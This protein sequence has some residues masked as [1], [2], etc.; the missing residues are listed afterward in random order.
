MEPSV[1]THGPLEKL[2]EYLRI[3][4]YAF[5]S[6]YFFH[7]LLI[8]ISLKIYQHWSRSTLAL[9]RWEL[10]QWHHNDLGGVSNHRRPNCLFN[11]LFKR[12]SKKTSKLRVTGL[13]EGNPP[14]TGGFPSQRASNVENVSI[15]WHHHDAMHPWWMS[16]NWVGCGW[17]VGW[18]VFSPR[19]SPVGN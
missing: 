3:F 17:V 13:C 16:V 7:V 18:R 19:M 4:S 10:L 11:R 8:T 1:L 15:W 2:L 6:V 9:K 14:V 5:S 12:R